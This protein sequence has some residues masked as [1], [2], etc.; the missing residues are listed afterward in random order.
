MDVWDMDNSS[1]VPDARIFLVGHVC[2]MGG[3]LVDRK[4]L[5]QLLAIEQIFDLEQFAEC[6]GEVCS[7]FPTLISWFTGRW[8]A[9]K[10][11][12][13]QSIHII[14]LIMAWIEGFFD[15]S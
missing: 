3:G 4:Q 1:A 9:P 10:R 6:D 7:T 14:H 8:E 12:Y 5:L 2:S 11:M 15:P 13:M